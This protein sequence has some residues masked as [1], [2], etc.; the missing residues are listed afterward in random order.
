LAC[1]LV[2]LYVAVNIGF[3]I[4]NRVNQPYRNG[5]KND[6]DDNYVYLPP[7][8]GLSSQTKITSNGRLRKGLRF[9]SGR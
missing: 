2:V 8:S 3:G 1:V 9:I 5:Y 7:R 4:E 6:S